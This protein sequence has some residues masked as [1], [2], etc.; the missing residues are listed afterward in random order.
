M[1]VHEPRP[2]GLCHVDTRARLDEG[3]VVVIVLLTPHGG[4][5]RCRAV[6]SRVIAYS[7][8]ALFN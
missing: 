3:M 1:V 5:R 8:G 6:V 2:E 4:N 7:H